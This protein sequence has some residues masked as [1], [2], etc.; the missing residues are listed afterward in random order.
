MGIE[1]E[2]QD[3]RLTCVSWTPYLINIVAGLKPRSI[4]HQSPA[5]KVKMRGGWQLQGQWNCPDCPCFS[6]C[7]GCFLTLC[8]KFMLLCSLLD[9]FTWL[10]VSMEDPLP[11]PDSQTKLHKSMG[12]NDSCP[13]SRRCLGPKVYRSICVYT[14]NLP[15]VRFTSGLTGGLSFHGCEY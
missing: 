14:G 2:N 3:L 4:W 10:R 13:V 15:G 8:F 6:L 12:H 1:E 7:V 11:L 9:F 5:Q